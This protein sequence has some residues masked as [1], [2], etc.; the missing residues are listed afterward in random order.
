MLFSFSSLMVFSWYNISTILRL[1][2]I[3]ISCISI[4]LL[5]SGFSV[6]YLFITLTG[7][8]FSFIFTLFVDYFYPLDNNEKKK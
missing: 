1:L 2:Y 7:G 4:Y 5:W 6:P 8:V 3:L